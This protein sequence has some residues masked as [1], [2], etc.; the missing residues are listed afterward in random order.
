MPYARLN[1]DGSLSA[2]DFIKEKEYPARG[3]KAA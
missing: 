3:T 1:S 2:I